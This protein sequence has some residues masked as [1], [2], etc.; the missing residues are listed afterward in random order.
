MEY[1]MKIDLSNYPLKKDCFSKNVNEIF[2]KDFYYHFQNLMSYFI[3]EFGPRA[4]REKWQINQINNL[5]NISAQKSNFWKERVDGLQ[6]ENF[7]DLKKIPILTREELRHQTSLEGSLIEEQNTYRTSTSGSSGNPITVFVTNENENQNFYQQHMSMMTKTPDLSKNSLLLWASSEISYPGFTEVIDGSPIEFLKKYYEIGKRQTIKY[8]NPDLKLLKNKLKEINYQVLTC[9]PFLMESLLQYYSAEEMKADGL[10][11]WEFIG[12]NP[13]EHVYEALTKNNIKI[14]SNYN[15]EELG[16]IAY[17]CPHNPFHY[18]VVASNVYLE[19]IDEGL[20]IK[21]KKVG[22]ILVTKINSYATP[23]IRYDNGDIATLLDKCPCGHDGQT[24]TNIHGRSKNLIKRK[25]GSV[26]PFLIQIK[27]HPIL[28][29]FKEYRFT[30]K[31]IDLIILEVSGKDSL[32]STDIDLLS[33]IVY[34]QAGTDIRVEIQ[35]LDK[36]DWNKKKIPF[37]SFVI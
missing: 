1:T 25:D 27:N 4:S 7:S 13:S 12:G 20:K 10:E 11:H 14:S 22:K 8:A 36:I 37:R 34:D 23:I 28:K 29:E 21:D 30:Q 5:I 33:Q 32:T 24:I 6:I 2:E 3:L 26:F 35:L 9:N 17:E 16:L 18:H 19:C 31:E 15:S